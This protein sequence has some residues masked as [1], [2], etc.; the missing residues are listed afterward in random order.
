MNNKKEEV[1]IEY[2]LLPNDSIK[3][4][5]RIVTQKTQRLQRV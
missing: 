3:F 1:K 4:G 2:K 5:K